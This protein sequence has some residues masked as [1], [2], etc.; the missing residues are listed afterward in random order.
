MNTSTEDATP[1]TPSS[2]IDPSTIVGIIFGVL[3]TVI[4]LLGL[5]IAWRQLQLAAFTSYL[6]SRI[7]HRV[8]HRL[9]RFSVEPTNGQVA[10]DGAVGLHS[11]ELPTADYSTVDP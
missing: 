5:I 3:A 11:P 2:G 10:A 9:I 4:A 8:S 1:I 7:L 6:S